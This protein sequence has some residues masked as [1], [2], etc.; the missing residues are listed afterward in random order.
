[1][2]LIV[3]HCAKQKTTIPHYI[4][5]TLQFMVLHCA[6]QKTTVPLWHYSSYNKTKS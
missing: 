6:K 2:Q 1:M 4:Y 3:L 5:V